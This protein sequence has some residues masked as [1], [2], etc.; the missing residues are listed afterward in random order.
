MIIRIIFRESLILALSLPFKN[1]SLFII[2]VLGIQLGLLSRL[3]V[4]T[5]MEWLLGSCKCLAWTGNCWRLC[6]NFRL[7]DRT[8][9]CLSRLLDLLA[10]FWHCKGW[11]IFYWGLELILALF[12]LFNLAGKG[13]RGPLSTLKNKWSIDR[14]SI[15]LFKKRLYYLRDFFQR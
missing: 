12:R 2:P 3:L 15:V 13:L 10:T 8:F 14:W 5:R 11:C 4:V 6:L 1:Q 9:A 7:L